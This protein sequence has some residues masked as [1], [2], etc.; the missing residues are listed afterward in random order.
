MTAGVYPHNAD[1]LKL[2]LNLGV[3]GKDRNYDYENFEKGIA[4]YYNGLVVFMNANHL[5]MTAFNELTMNM[6]ESMGYSI[7]PQTV[8]AVPNL[9]TTD[10]IPYLIKDFVNNCFGTGNYDAEGIKSMIATR[11]EPI[12]MAIAFQIDPMFN[13]KESVDVLVNEFRRTGNIHQIV[14]VIM[15]NSCYLNKREYVRRGFE[16]SNESDLVDLLVANHC[17]GQTRI[18]DLK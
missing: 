2:C 9:R 17:K 10:Y 16:E 11:V 6:L 4:Y 18:L 1:F 14:S 13:D 15:A 5:Y 7:S 8:C 3:A 12:R